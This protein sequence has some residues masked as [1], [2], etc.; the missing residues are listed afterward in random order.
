MTDSA[1]E[2]LTIADRL[3][4]LVE[5]SKVS[6]IENNLSK[7][8]DAAEQVGKAWSGSNLG[9][10]AD[11]YYADLKSPPA[12]A[13]FNPEWGLSN[14]RRITGAW[15]AW[16]P[17]D[18]K[19]AIYLLSGNPD[20]AP[21]ESVSEK[22]KKLF[23][24]E[25][26]EIVSILVNE[27]ASCEDTFIEN[28][29]KEAEGI[30][31]LL[32]GEIIAELLPSS[33]RMTRDSMAASQGSRVPSHISV[34]A[35]TLA[36]K[37]PIEACAILSSIARKAGSH[38]ARM[39]RKTKKSEMVGTNI[40]IGHGKSHAWRDLKDFVKDRLNLPHDEFNRIPVAGVT[41]IARLLEML[42]SA[43][44]AF[45]VMTAEDEQA[46]GKVHARMNVVHEAGLFQGRLSFTKAIVILEDG[47]EEFSNI[48]GLCQIRFPKGNISAAFEEIRMVLERENII[49][50]EKKS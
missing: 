12:D 8:S 28:L 30:R 31:Y 24:A 47:C 43:A 32:I 36:L 15:Q 50:E 45:L 25:K 42:D 27:L 4:A 5:Q 3:D 49:P 35:E 48:Q 46:D 16:K 13:P 26:S 37:Q 39:K 21:A 2:L 17:D 11:V 14:T 7:L 18:V 10:H 9:Y 6:Q 22:A 33:C 40:F 34:Q 1:A 29:K 20:L 23:D 38:I 44:I 19:D 41:N